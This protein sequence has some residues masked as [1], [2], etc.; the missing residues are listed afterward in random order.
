MQ[1]KKL[2]FLLLLLICVLSR[3]SSFT[4]TKTILVNR[5]MK[6]HMTTEE[7]A[8][9]PKAISCE[10]EGSCGQTRRAYKQELNK[11]REEKRKN[12]QDTEDQ[13]TL[14]LEGSKPPIGKTFSPFGRPQQK[15]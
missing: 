12:N 5:C 15:R 2:Y 9:K 10:T 11:I 4:T 1:Q 8:G 14:L 7:E 13:Y 3:I 6:P